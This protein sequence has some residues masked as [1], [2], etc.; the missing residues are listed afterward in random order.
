VNLALAYAPSCL[1]YRSSL[2]TSPSQQQLRPSDCFALSRTSFV[3]S[4]TRLSRY[5][6]TGCHRDTSLPLGPLLKLHMVSLVCITLSHYSCYWFATLLI[7]YLRQVGYVLVVTPSTNTDRSALSLP[8]SLRSSYPRRVMSTRYH[9]AGAPAVCRSRVHLY[10]HVHLSTSARFRGTGLVQCSYL[11]YSH[12]LPCTHSLPLSRSGCLH[13]LSHR[14]SVVHLTRE[15]QCISLT[16][17]S[18]LR[19]TV[20]SQ[21]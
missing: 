3:P 6:C 9:P 7:A 19:T 11:R 13:L 18:P 15:G 8:P 2:T 5:P 1:V 14:C 10:H 16:Q 12:P 17:H 21:T 20:S 4:T